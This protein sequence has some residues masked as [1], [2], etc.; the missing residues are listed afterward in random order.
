MKAR[1][2]NSI[3][4]IALAATAFITPALAIPVPAG[5]PSSSGSDAQQV[6]QS[7]RSPANS[8][9]EAEGDEIWRDNHSAIEAYKQ[10]KMDA[11]QASLK[12]VT[13]AL[14]LER[15][16]E[17]S[18]ARALSNLSLILAE[19]SK[20]E[21][22]KAAAWQAEKLLRQIFNSADTAKYKSAGLQ[23]IQP[24]STLRQKEQVTAGE[25]CSAPSHAWQ[26]DFIQGT[27]LKQQG[28]YKEAE[29]YLVA[30]AK[31]A[32][33]QA[34]SPKDLSIVYSL[35]GGEY[36]YLERFDQSIITYKKALSLAEAD[37]GKNTANYA[38][39]L[40]NLAQ[41]Y[42][43]KGDF[44]GAAALQQESIAIYEKVLPPTAP[45]LAEV[46]CNYA[47]TL[48]HTGNAAA[49]QKYYQRSIEIY[50]ASV[51]PDDL[52]LAFAL[53]NF[54]S[55]YSHTGRLSQA[56][57]M[58]RKALNIF[59]S[60]LGPTHPD[61]TICLWNLANTLVQAGSDN[62][63]RKLL[64]EHIVALKE[65]NSAQLPSFLHKYARL[66]NV[67]LGRQKH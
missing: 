47:E 59:C 10:G 67:I 38:T 66:M 8:G 49:A 46:F 13:A 1:F 32:A 53:D 29:P 6:E 14:E 56:E 44:A 60:K 25:A 24:T 41:V 39:I 7:W 65:G 63:A 9:Q 57:S 40:D 11:A 34:A 35:L 23:E 48:S 4:A 27:R 55:L 62:E 26:E 12:K 33:A 21:E 15:G 31:E 17:L 18:L 45:D 64:E 43:Q 22:S 28:R 42:N 20:S 61:V 58:Q 30:A 2:I 36:R 5:P 52:R 37:S 51:P 19:Q 3:F 50:Q 54:A 16:S